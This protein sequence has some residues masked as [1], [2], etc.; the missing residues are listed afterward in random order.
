MPIRYTYDL[1]SNTTEQYIYPSFLVAG[2]R[3]RNGTPAVITVYDGRRRAYSVQPGS[4]QAF[5][6]IPGSQQFSYVSSL[7][8]QAGSAGMEI[9]DVPF[10]MDGNA[11]Q[12][13][14]GTVPVSVQN[15]SISVTGTVTASISGPVTVTG[16]LNATITNATL[17]VSDTAVINNTTALLGLLTNNRVAFGLVPGT[18]ATLTFAAASA[19]FGL[20]STITGAGRL[21]VWV[22]TASGDLYLVR[23]RGFYASP[24]TRNPIEKRFAVPIAAGESLKISW[25]DAITNANFV[26]RY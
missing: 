2:I 25:D 14:P 5:D 8:S 1:Q 13:P 22:S 26:L 19:G 24:M 18:V 23:D 21:N 9:S 4:T 12:Q 20:T 11:Q 15:A 6:I 3:V 7:A 17:T 10:P 16:T